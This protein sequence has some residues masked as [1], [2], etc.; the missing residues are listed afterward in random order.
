MTD[1]APTAELLPT[2]YLSRIY[3]RRDA[4]RGFMT[5]AV[6]LVGFMTDAVLP[7]DL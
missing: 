1:A 2:R 4:C 3:D 6:L 5:D 7:A